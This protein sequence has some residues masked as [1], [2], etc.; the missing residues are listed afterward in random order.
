[1]AVEG[2]WAWPRCIGCGK[3]VAKKKP[4]DIRYGMDVC[5]ANCI[6]KLFNQDYRVAWPVR[7]AA[8]TL[9]RY[10]DQEARG[11]NISED[12]WQKLA[13]DFALAW[14]KLRDHY[15]MPEFPA[16]LE[17]FIVEILNDRTPRY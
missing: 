4:K 15:Q 2:E 13:K 10:T 11:L 8:E 16:G 9:K 17:L 6:Q 14:A 5:C 3:K 12:Y 1:M 7:S